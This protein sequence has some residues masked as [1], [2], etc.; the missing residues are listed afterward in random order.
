MVSD[1]MLRMN[2]LKWK[3]EKTSLVS[4]F[5]LDAWLI[6]QIFSSRAVASANASKG[7]VTVGVQILAGE[8]HCM[9]QSDSR[10]VEVETAINPWP[11]GAPKRNTK[12]RLPRLHEY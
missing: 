7:T 10:R 12:T 8:T 1:Y 6:Q 11:A 2:F 3:A 4:S 9:T 5:L